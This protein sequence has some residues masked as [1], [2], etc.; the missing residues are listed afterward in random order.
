MA[1][2]DFYGLDPL[3]RGYVE[4]LRMLANTGSRAEVEAMVSEFEAV[5][6]A[7]YRQDLEDDYLGWEGVLLAREG[8]YEEAIATLRKR[9]IRACE[10]CR[11]I[12]LAPIY[13]AAGV[14]DSA[15]ALYERYV[16]AFANYRIFFDANRLG[17][18]LERLGQLYDGQGDLENAAVYYAR[19]VE[20]WADADSELQPR[21]E[22]ARARLEEIIRERG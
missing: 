7:E 6:P 21:V 5:V 18:A 12:P 17:P 14:A 2:D 22:A 13:D 9:E 11:Y 8:R 1:A 20:L 15:V 10:L 4:V 16:N 3:D 19:F